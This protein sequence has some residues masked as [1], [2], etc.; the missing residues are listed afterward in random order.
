[1][2]QALLLQFPGP[3][4][5][6]PNRS[7]W[8]LL[9]A[10]SASFAA[11]GA[12]VLVK[13][14]SSAMMWF[15]VLFFAVCA[16]VFG[17]YLLPGSASLTLDTDGFRVKHFYF[18]RK[19]HWQTVT[20]I[21][22]ASAPPSRTKFVRYNDTQWNGWKLAR[23]ETARLGYNAMLPDTYGMSADD[24][25]ELMTQWR[26]RVLGPSFQLSDHT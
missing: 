3:L 12:V 8:I 1:M 14:D 19:S 6:Y 5:L 10:V 11:F 18:V 26:D 7:K 23:W 17:A 25:A 21:Q 16:V 2:M 4:T 20:N 15:C 13:Q 9:F 24:L 22:A